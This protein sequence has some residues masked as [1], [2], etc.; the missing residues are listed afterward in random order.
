MYIKF[1]PWPAAR[2]Q[3]YAVLATLMSGLAAMPAA[4]SDFYEDCR[5][6][7]GQFVRQGDELRR[8]NPATGE[9][10][11]RAV[12]HRVLSRI[13]IAKSAGYCI[14]DRTSEGRK[15]YP[16]E[17]STY[18]LQIS[19]R[20]NGANNR[21]FLLCDTASDGLPAAYSCDRLQT[22]LDWVH[23]G[24]ADAGDT[25]RPEQPQSRRSVSS[26]WNHNGSEMEIV[27]EGSKRWIRYVK[28]RAALVARGVER[29]TELFVG[30]RQNGRY[31]GK[32][33][34]FTS[35]CGP[36]AYEV[37]GDV[38]ADERRV[39]LTGRAPLVDKRCRVKSW[40]DDR[41]VFELRR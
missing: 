10:V 37:E 1:K 32:A 2:W 19:Y 25:P 31:F 39:V 12:P 15:R 20:D 38:S 13:D 34:V 33:Y 30:E 9:P 17:A 8:I 6:A 29:G 7:D 36:Q 18:V 4:A 14:V 28:P 35:R 26:G 24:S 41:L 16:H 27:A 22:T 40:R 5:S 21:V 11:G 3:G 23:G